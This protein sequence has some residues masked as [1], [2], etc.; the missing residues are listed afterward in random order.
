MSLSD[1][2]FANRLNTNYVP[3]H[4]EIL[5]IRALLV[6]PT[7]EVARVD[8]QI[9][10]MELVLTQLKAKRA[11]L[12]QSIDAHKALISPMRLIP[13]D[14]LLEIFF[15]CLPSEHN[16]L[17]DPTEAPL[18][19]G[20]IC[21][22]WRSVAY[23]APMLWSSLHIPTPDYLNTPPHILSLFDFTNRVDLNPDL[24]QHP[25]APQ[26][27]A[28][29]RRLRWLALGGDA[30]LIRPILQLDSRNLPLLKTFRMQTMSNQAPSSTNIFELATLEDVALTMSTNPLTLPLEWSKL[31]ILHLECHI[32]WT[33]H[34]PEGGLDFD[35]ALDVL[36]RCPNLEWCE[37][38]VT[39]YSEPSGSNPSPIILPRL[40]TLVFSGWE[41]TLQKWISDL[42]APNLSFI[43]IGDVNIPWSRSNDEQHFSVDVDLHRF[44]SLTS[45]REFLQTFS[46][47][48]HL[49]LVANSYHPNHI[50]LLD[51]E[52]MTLFCPPHSLCPKL[53]DFEIIVPPSARVS[54]AAVLAFI[55]ARMTMS[56]PL[57][58][59]HARFNRP[60]DL[61]LIPELQSFISD[62]L[63]VN[64]E[65]PPPRWRSFKARDGL[66]E[67]G[68]FH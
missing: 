68:T 61:D 47:I 48:S 12:Q 54:D 56:I 65:Y 39:K 3:S 15:A 42:V 7:E 11:V 28:V 6:D 13:Q 10:E 62:G 44:T 21:R 27:L 63:Q 14:I 33:E 30:E 24:E 60:V 8:A 55:Q 53:I 37:M 51:D 1:S 9:E 22:H 4:S 5:E 17:I 66:D 40:H 25:L 45:L 16:A 26:I 23:S 49:H 36:R 29:S 34:G 18:L 19:L 38:R 32:H 67:P 31:R 50:S 2:S 59:F 20:R 43:Q 41:F 58:R 57:Q 46:M 52:F 64:L 35:G